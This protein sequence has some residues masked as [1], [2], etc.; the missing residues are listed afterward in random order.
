METQN[1]HNFPKEEV[2][3]E[4]LETEIGLVSFYSNIVVVEANE[5]IT[6][7]YK[8]GFS[9]LLKGL[10]IV[11]LRPF[12]YIANRINSYSVNPNDYKYLNNIP[13]IKA[14]AIVSQ[15]EKARQSAEWEK[16]FST[17]PLEVFEDLQQ[18]YK[19]ALQI[20]KKQ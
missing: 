6:L 10:K 1:H 19:W 18:A 4:T 3:Q 7:S 5:G 8:T 11:G 13:T 20:L 2:L 9:V 15:L 12:V 14:I 17:K 16:S